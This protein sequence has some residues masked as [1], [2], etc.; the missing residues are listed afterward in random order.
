MGFHHICQIVFAMHQVFHENGCCFI[1]ALLMKEYFHFGHLNRCFRV[2]GNICFMKGQASDQHIAAND[3]SAGNREAGCNDGDVI[4]SQTI[5][6]G[7]G[8]AAQIAP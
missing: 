4:L 3:D 7:I 2:D 5:Q 8:F 6:H 1:F